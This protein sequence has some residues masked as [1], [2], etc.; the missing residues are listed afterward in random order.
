ML[1]L[2]ETAAG[3]ALYELKNEAKLKGLDPDKLAL[4]L[5]TEGGAAKALTLKKFAP[6]RDTTEAVAA[7]TDFV[8]SK[9]NKQLK[10]FLKK[11]RLILSFM[12][13]PLKEWTGV[14]MGA[15]GQVVKIDYTRRCKGGDVGNLV[16]PEGMLSVDLRRCKGLTGKAES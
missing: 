4:K 10:K 16:L 9:L 3:H 2:F 7:A 12:D 14:N 8:E 13:V 5:N 1:L 6:F 15:D 11:F